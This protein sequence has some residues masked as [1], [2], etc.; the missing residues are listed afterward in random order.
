MNPVLFTSILNSK[1]T[2]AAV[3]TLF[4]ILVVAVVIL[5][6]RSAVKKI[7]EN[8]RKDNIDEF[9]NQMAARFYDTLFPYSTWF[10]WVVP[11][12]ELKIIELA[13]ETGKKRIDEVA[14][15]YRIA[16]D[17]YLI[18]DIQ[19]ELTTTQQDEFFKALA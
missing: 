8:N 14:K 9:Q 2:K 12:D 13:K 7:R 18:D 16:Y 6:S 4:I 15:A 3:N 17:R 11:V 10:K 19:N 5:V 1:A